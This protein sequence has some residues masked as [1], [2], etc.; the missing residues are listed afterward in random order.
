MKYDIFA[1]YEVGVGE[2]V[3][4]RGFEEQERRQELIDFVTAHS[5]D[6][7]EAPLDT[8]SHILT[9]STCT[10]RGYATR[11]VVQAVWNEKPETPQMAEQENVAPN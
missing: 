5:A 4:Q 7:I 10:G 6:G 1:A 11:W 9:L 2:I 3:Y 8:D